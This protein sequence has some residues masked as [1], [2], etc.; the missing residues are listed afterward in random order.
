MLK[1]LSVDAA[2]ARRRLSVAF[3]GAL[4]YDIQC[5]KDA[6]VSAGEYTTEEAD[7]MSDVEWLESCGKR[8]SPPEQLESNLEAFAAACRKATCPGSGK[9]WTQRSE[10][11]HQRQL[12]RVRDGWYSGQSLSPSRSCCYYYHYY[13]HYHYGPSGACQGVDAV[14]GMKWTL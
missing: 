10:E 5:I 4:A 9:L 13:H 8:I 2:W 1:R 7:A 12:Q 14:K 6:A 11:L 3:F